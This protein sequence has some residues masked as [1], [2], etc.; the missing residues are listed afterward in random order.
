[1]GTFYTK[2][3]EEWLP[4]VPTI[5]RRTTI[6]IL[7]LAVG[8][9]YNALDAVSLAVKEYAESSWPLPN[10]SGWLLDAHWGPY[11][12]ISRNGNP[13]DQFRLFIRAKR[14]LNRSWGAA[15]QALQIF[16]LLLPPAA[17]L[18]FTPFYPKN[19]VITIGGVPLD[20]TTQAIAFMTKAPSPLGGGF[21]VC[22]D[23][24][25]AVAADAIVFTYTSIYGTEG[26]EFDVVGWFT[27]IHYPEYPDPPPDAEGTAGY[28]HAVTI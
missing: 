15:D 26:V 9:T 24:G 8:Q 11:H 4:K 3:T 12:N 21:S 6:N 22:G 25:L 5:L 17:T 28:A 23:N 27:S 20:Q 1:M 19:W 13:D 18:T 2:L 10:A 7:N 16:E 14:L